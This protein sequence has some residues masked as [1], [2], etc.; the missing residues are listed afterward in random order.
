MYL[1]DHVSLHGTVLK[2][3]VNDAVEEDAGLCVHFVITILFSLYHRSP[4]SK[5]EPI[6]SIQSREY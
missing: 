2:L 6:M 4:I 1:L 5:S 3:G